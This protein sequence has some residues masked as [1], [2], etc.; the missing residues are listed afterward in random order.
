MVPD[1]IVVMPTAAIQRHV[2]AEVP[3]LDVPAVDGITIKRE[4]DD[5][6][7]R[8]AF[9]IIAAVHAFRPEWITMQM[10]VFAFP[11]VSVANV[12]LARFPCKPTP[13]VVVRENR[14]SVDGNPHSACRWHAWHAGE[15]GGDGVRTS[16]DGG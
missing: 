10:V 15:R 14:G 3:R 16:L 13:V 11:R 6:G 9:I 2:F 5:W 7:V 4:A 8:D 1:A 12:E